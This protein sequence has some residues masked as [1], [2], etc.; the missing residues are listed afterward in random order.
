MAGRRARARVQAPA[1]QPGVPGGERHAAPPATLFGVR[2]GVRLD[3]RDAAS[4]SSKPRLGT[5][6]DSGASRAADVEPTVAQC[7]ALVGAFV[8][9]DEW[10]EVLLGAVRPGERARDRRRRAGGNGRVLRGRGG[11]GHAPR[12][13]RRRRFLSLRPDPGRLGAPRSSVRRTPPRDPPCAASRRRCSRAARGPGAAAGGAR[14]PETGDSR[15]CWARCSAPAPAKKRSL[16]ATKPRNRRARVA[17]RSRRRRARSERGAQRAFRRNAR[18]ERNDGA[19]ARRARAARRATRAARGARAMPRRWRPSAASGDAASGG[20]AFDAEDASTAIRLVALVAEARAFEKAR[21]DCARRARAVSEGERRSSV[22]AAGRGHRDCFLYHSLDA[23]LDARESLVHRRRRDRRRV[24]R[25]TRDGDGGAAR[26]APTPPRAPPP[27]PSPRARS[28]SWKASRTEPPRRKR[29]GFLRAQVCALAGTLANRLTVAS[30]TKEKEPS[31]LAAPRVL[32]RLVPAHPP[33]WTTPTRRRATRRRR[34]SPRWPRRRRSRRTTARARRP[35][36]TSS[37]RARART[38]APWQRRDPAAAHEAHPSAAAAAVARHEGG[39]AARARRAPRSPPRRASRTR[40]L[41][42][43]RRRAGG[44]AAA[45][46]AISEARDSDAR[47][48][49]GAATEEARRRDAPTA[50]FG[51]D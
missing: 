3:A 30:K 39:G 14:A 7:C 21:L 16:P 20:V 25:G 6:S 8:K 11:G 19:S 35:P 45:L 48:A 34:R 13:N 31:V 42:R 43:R 37:K 12:N 51:L 4:T 10:L 28:P 41:R 29:R 33:G 32:E 46:R 24:E 5:Q 2:Q 15:V 40:R 36:R 47:V 1:R 27:A 23:H 50:L 49:P 17:R 44:G 18:A 9:P 26:R 22:R 38:R